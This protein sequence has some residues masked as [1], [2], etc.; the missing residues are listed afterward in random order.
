MYGEPITLA[1][2][3][4]AL[5]DNILNDFMIMVQTQEIIDNK[6]S[7]GEMARAKQNIQ[8]LKT[9]EWI[10]MIIALVCFSTLLS[11]H[12]IIIY[13][14]AV[15]AMSYMFIEAKILRNI[16][17]KANKVPQS[18]ESWAASDAKLLKTSSKE[19]EK[20]MAIDKSRDSANAKKP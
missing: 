15:P 17:K 18:F 20:I 1:K 16:E 2:V 11:A 12:P 3:L 14:F 19:V 8:K 6:S 5:K 13:G 9:E 4:K 7:P 10:K